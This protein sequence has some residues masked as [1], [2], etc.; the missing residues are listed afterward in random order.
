MP[1]REQESQIRGFGRLLRA[2]LLRDLMNG[3]GDVSLTAHIK[4][5]FASAEISE[6]NVWRLMETENWPTD[7]AIRQLGEILPEFKY[8]A[9][10]S[11]SLRGDWDMASL[12]QKTLPE[13]S[14]ITI[15][16]AAEDPKAL[17]DR[18]IAGSVAHNTLVRKMSYI[19]LFPP[20]SKDP[21]PMRVHLVGAV[22]SAAFSQQSIAE[23]AGPH[24]TWYDQLRKRIHV[25]VT[26][27]SDESWELWSSAPRYTVLYNARRTTPDVYPQYGMYWSH[28]IS[29]FSSP[30]VENPEKVSGWEFLKRSDSQRLLRFIEDEGEKV[31][32]ETDFEDW[33][34]PGE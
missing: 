11:D 31:L 16:A 21:A 4:A 19:F 30:L 24:D 8:A 22:L 12:D 32:N 28:G 29:I 17:Y 14:T 18:G 34:I 7:T 1:P 26:Q 2:S 9:A 10:N 20:H 13:R 15:L 25:F 23:C 33:P 27:K 5:R 6:R 3:D